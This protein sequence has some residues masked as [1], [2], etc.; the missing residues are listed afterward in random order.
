MKATAAVPALIAHLRRPETSPVAA[1][2]IARALA[3]IGATEALP[4]LRDFVTMYRADPIYDGD[5]TALVA[6]SEAMLALGGPAERELLLYLTEEPHTV[7]ALRVHLRRA[8]T[9]TAGTAG[10]PA[11]DTADE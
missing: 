5:P 11:A 9:Q 6:A 2:Q 10:A 3:A 4:A 1:T 7:E 8:L